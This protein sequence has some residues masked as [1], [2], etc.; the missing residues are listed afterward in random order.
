MSGDW[1]EPMADTGTAFIMVYIQI[2][3]RGEEPYLV[4]FVAKSGGQTLASDPISV[5]SGER[6]EFRGHRFNVSPGTWKIHASIGERKS[7]SETVS[8]IAG[9]NKRVD[10]TFTI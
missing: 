10:L 9:E 3:G 8:V 4:R 6:G 5:N 2:N 1:E 7:E